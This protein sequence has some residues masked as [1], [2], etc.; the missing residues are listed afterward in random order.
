MGT[1]KN[2]MNIDTFNNAKLDIGIVLSINGNLVL[3]LQTD[4]ADTSKMI[5]RNNTLTK[6]I[7]LSSGNY[8]A[9]KDFPAGVY[10]VIATKGSGNISSSNLYKGGLNE[11]MGIESN[12]FTIKEFKHAIF[13]EGVTLSISGVSI[14]LVPSK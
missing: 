4:Q 11:V 13:D 9:G 14:K 8:T 5:E 3:N 1:E 10:D 12:D 7:P 2:D 6:T